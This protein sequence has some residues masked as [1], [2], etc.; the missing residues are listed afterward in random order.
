MAGLPYIGLK[1]EGT[2][3][4]GS[5]S[6]NIARAAASLYVMPN[7]MKKPRLKYFKLAE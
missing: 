6:S 7:A 5:P 3:M 2:P 1:K 4:Y